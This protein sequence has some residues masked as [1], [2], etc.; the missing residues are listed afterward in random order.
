MKQESRGRGKFKPAQD[1]SEDEIRSVLY[2]KI[3]EEMN[4]VAE[5]D[6]EL[7]FIDLDYRTD[8]FNVVSLFS[9]CGGLDL[10]F[11]V[12]GLAEVLGEEEALRIF[13]DKHDFE[14]NRHHSVFHTVYT[15]DLFVEAN[16]TYN[17]HFPATV[18]Q[19]QRDIRKVAKFPK[20]DLV[21]GGFPCP[22]FS[23]AGPRLL[24][25]KRNFLYLHFIR[26]LMQSSPKIFVAEN[27]RGMM[28]L[29]KGE[30]LKQIKQDFEAA[31]YTVNV[32]LLNAMD[33]GV[34]QSR[35][36]VFLVGVK[37]GID[38]KYNEPPHRTHGPGT[39]VT[40]RDSI[41]DLQ[42]EPGPYFE[43]SFSKIYLSRNRKKSWDDVSFTI[44]ASGRH[45]PLHPGGSKMVKVG[46]DEWILPGEPTQ[47]RRLSVREIARIQTFPD[48][49]DFTEMMR[50]DISESGQLDKQYKQIGNAVPV[51]L[52]KAVANPI[53]KFARENLLQD[54]AVK[55]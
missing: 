15:N 38:F 43:G 45:A 5:M 7:D 26:C 54:V 49:F 14:K 11:E 1:M 37:K 23:E 3:E 41:W 20:A 19:H 25:D 6:E 9:G 32:M 21:L 27:V 52:A 28:T 17:R 40:L 55:N 44:Q 30:V 29:G 35:E 22:G 18:F 46:P 2:S 36:R 50:S 10:G 31:G 8:K 12:A 24:D 4:E 13:K 48:W 42:N 53:A 34:P 47:H 39:Y 16:Q 33:Y 51:L